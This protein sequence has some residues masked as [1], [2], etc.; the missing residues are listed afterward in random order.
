MWEL[1][2]NKVFL[3]ATAVLTGT[4]V[5]VGIFSI[6]LSFTKS[7]FFIGLI[8][9]FVIG[10]ITI[11]YNLIFAEIILRTQSS[12]QLVG[13][14]RRYLR[15]PWARRIVFFAN[16]LGIYGALLVYIH[17]AGGFL[18]N[19]LSEFFFIPRQ[20]Y[21]L[22]F[23]LLVSS[24]LPFGFRTVAG[25]EFFITALFII[26]T[27]S[28]F[29][30]GIQNIDV[31]NLTTVDVSYWFLPYGVL[32][33]AFAGL[34]SIPLQRRLL[35][36]QE[37]NFKRSIVFAVVLSGILYALFA[38]TVVG[39]SGFS[40]SDDA[41][42][43][44][45]EFVGPPLILLASFFGICTITTSFLMLASA[46][47]DIFYLDFRIRRKSS[48]LLTVI[49][50]LVL[51]LSGLRSVV[52]IISL[53]GAVGIGTEVI[54]LLFIFRKA[55]KEGDRTPEF[56]MSIPNWVSI[57]LGIVFMIGIVFALFVRD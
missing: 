4:M 28:I 1:L 27:L 32:L 54:I 43:G 39:V 26:V 21:S 49:P 50:P 3:H 35:H 6:P 53:V 36:G 14:T 48:W 34:S 23:F 29:G 25:I 47:S 16:A 45:R 31:A 8:L 9:L 52:D 33:F 38:L 11:L 19:L 5:G 55:K 20:Y 41:L 17:Y 56:S 10:A 30:V 51:Y 46:L 44:L 13:Y 57:L 37:H 22:G 42:S 18:D 15:S 7:G 24:I 40:T 2:K 12:H